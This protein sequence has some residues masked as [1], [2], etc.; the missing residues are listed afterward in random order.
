MATYRKRGAVWQV[1]VNR[2]GVRKAASFRTKAEATSW[3]SKVEAEIFAG[4]RGEIPDKPVRELLERYQREV[5]P[6]KR[7]QRWEQVRIGLLLRDKLAEVRLPQL[8]ASD[9]AAWRDRRLQT[10]SAASVI[11]EW[12]LLSSV[13]SIAINEWRWLRE[14]PFKTV[15]RPK[16]PPLRDRRIS[17][18][19][20]DRLILAL[21][22]TPSAALDAIT[23]RVGAAVLFAV[24]TAMR[25]SEI[26]ALTWANVSGAVAHLPMT[27]N[28]TARSVALS[29]AAQS[30]IA[31]LPRISDAVFDLQTSQIDALFRKAKAR[32][33]I[34]DLHFHDTRHEAIT[35]LARKLDVLDLARMVGIRDLRILM[36]YY[37]AKPAEIAERLA[38]SETTT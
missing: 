6:T 38:V 11:R 13:F 5:T 9:V 18:D 34:A 24:E 7:G 15:K 27:K 23:A 19:E 2:H 10:V 8:S 33:L 3:A 12:A 1:Q 22:Y 30:I 25:A 21:G 16:T 14:N 20:I 26:C 17:Q 29:P 36:V 32:A 31:Q 35:R 4:I 28:G 37:N